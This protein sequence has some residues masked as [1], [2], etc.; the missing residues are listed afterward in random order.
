[1]FTTFAPKAAGIGVPG[2]TAS[3]LTIGYATGPDGKTPG[4]LTGVG[5][6]VTLRAKP[7]LLAPGYGILSLAV[8]NSAL[9]V[10]N[11]QF[12]VQ[13]TIQTAYPPYLSLSGTSMAAPQVAGA[14]ALMLEAN[15]ALTPNLVKGILQYTAQTDPD[16]NSLEQ[17]TGFLD[18]LSA[19]RLSMFYT[20]LWGGVAI[21]FATFASLL[22]NLI[23][24]VNILG[25][26]FY[27]TVLGVFLTAF[28]L[29]FVRGTAV[30]VAALVAEATVVTLFL[31]SDIGFLWYNLIGCAVVMGVSLLLTVASGPRVLLISASTT[32]PTAAR[33]GF[34]FRSST[35]DT[36]RMFASRSSSPSFVRAETGT[37]G[38]SPPHSSI[39]TPFSDSSVFTRSGFAFSRSILFIATTMGTPAAFAW[40]MASFVCGMTPSSA[41]TTSTA[42]SV[43]C[44]PRARMAVNAS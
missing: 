11:P 36:T 10:A 4:G 34:A 1:M 6:G 19:V 7:D 38:V 33:S 8:P 17:G 18:V 39:T 27:G 26:L 42:T 3:A 28:F 2:D 14:V 25:S 30:F 35:S 29:H 41:A 24:A 43:T 32:M 16:L 22:D 31:T 9:Y 13:G 15:P 37:R 44:A 5:P 23:Q 12:L 40:S 20:V 21:G